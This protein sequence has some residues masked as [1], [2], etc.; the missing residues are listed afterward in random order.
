MFSCKEL[1][2][3]LACFVIG[4]IITVMFLKILE[5]LKVSEPARR[6][7]WGKNNRGSYTRS[8]WRRK[9]RPKNCTGIY[10][11]NNKVSARTRRTLR[12][13]YERLLFT[14]FSQNLNR[15]HPCKDSLRWRRGLR[16][17]ESSWPLCLVIISVI[18]KFSFLIICKLFKVSSLCLV[19]ENDPSESYFSPCFLKLS[20]TPEAN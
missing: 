10:N 8:R 18:G 13:C 1:C 20:W 15:V 11:A 19:S 2:R 5:W 17:S 12:Y 6:M 4:G 16:T 14:F 3:S 9:T 7:G